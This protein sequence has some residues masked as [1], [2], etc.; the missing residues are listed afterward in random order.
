MPKLKSEH[1]PDEYLKAIG[2]VVTSW[3]SLE[4]EIKMFL[5]H[6]LGKET[7][8]QRAH[9]VFAH[10]SFPQLLDILGAL[11]EDVAN[12]PKFIH[13]KNCDKI[14]APLLKQAQKSR[15]QIIHSEWDLNNKGQVS[16]ISISARGTFKFS[17]VLV[18]LEEIEKAIKDI[19]DTR[20]AIFRMILPFVKA[21]L[22]RDA[23]RRKRGRS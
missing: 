3:S 19:K 23:R 15:N 11:A 18:Q 13:A 4:F 17:G 20:T 14:L 2:S 1:L 5:I 9:A 21:D 22:R 8:D 7:I 10:M 6:L 12:D 16:R